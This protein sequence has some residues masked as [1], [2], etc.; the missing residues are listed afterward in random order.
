MQLSCHTKLILTTEPEKMKIEYFLE[1]KYTCQC[2]NRQQQQHQN[3]LRSVGSGYFSF[4][5]QT[6]SKRS[7]SNVN[8]ENALHKKERKRWRHWLTVCKSVIV[9]V[10]KY[11]RKCQKDEWFLSLFIILTVCHIRHFEQNDNMVLLYDV[12]VA[13]IWIDPND[14]RGF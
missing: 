3:A 8:N 10:G 13:L 2:N 11:E 4:F 14:R 9:E 12:F 7:E 6:N 1:R 5:C